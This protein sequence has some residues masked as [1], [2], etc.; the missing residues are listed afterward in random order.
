MYGAV[1]GLSYAYMFGTTPLN[2]YTTDVYGNIVN[3]VNLTY[4]WPA[5]TTHN[6]IG[7]NSLA[8]EF[9]SLNGGPAPTAISSSAIGLTSLDILSRYAFS[10]SQADLDKYYM[11]VE[12][13]KANI[14]SSIN[15]TSNIFAAEILNGDIVIKVV[16]KQF[17]G[18]FNLQSIYSSMYGVSW[19]ND[20]VFAGGVSEVPETAS[21]SSTQIKEILNRLDIV[22]SELGITYTN[23][24]ALNLNIDAATNQLLTSI[25][26]PNV[27]EYAEGSLYT[28]NGEALVAETD[29]VTQQPV[30]GSLSSEDSEAYAEQYGLN[31]TSTESLATDQPDINISGIESTST[32]NTSSSGTG[33]GVY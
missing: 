23:T 7:I 10:N 8:E 13:C 29:M 25:S 11:L 9:N 18:S 15:S 19:S 26:T 5:R 4:G 27:I 16:N 14:V 12:K 32:T 3:I 30:A 1:V 28:E 6:Y 22:A 24:E 33:G 21:Y 17:Y 20:A 31:E 2:L